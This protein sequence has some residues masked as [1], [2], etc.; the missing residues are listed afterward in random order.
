MIELFEQNIRT[1]GK[2]TVFSAAGG[3]DNGTAELWCIY[4]QMRKYSYLFSKG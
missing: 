2:I 3:A 4:A 1:R